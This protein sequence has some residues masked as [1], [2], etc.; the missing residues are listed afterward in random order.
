MQQSTTP[1]NPQ[2]GYSPQQPIQTVAAGYGSQQN[3]PAYTSQSQQQTTGGTASQGY[4]S[5]QQVCRYNVLFLA[6]I[7]RKESELMRS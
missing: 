1:G 6:Y 5:Q 3:A 4:S 2:H 7:L